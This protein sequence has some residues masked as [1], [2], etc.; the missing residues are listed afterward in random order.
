[1]IRQGDE[2][3][4]F[5]ICNYFPIKAGLDRDVGAV[6]LFGRFWAVDGVSFL[7]HA[8]GRAGLWMGLT[9]YGVI[10]KVH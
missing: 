6:G 3:V 7:F 10:V 1:M 2:I 8:K 4:P 9:V 5:K